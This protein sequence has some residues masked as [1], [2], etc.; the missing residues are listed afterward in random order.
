VKLF[1]KN[2][3]LVSGQD[4]NA[5]LSFVKDGGSVFR[6]C[7]GIGDSSHQIL[8][9]AGFVSLQYHPPSFDSDCDDSYFTFKVTD[10]G[11]E[12]AAKFPDGRTYQEI[13]AEKPTCKGMGRKG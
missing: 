9:D 13:I 11:S 8:V 10:Q 2:G 6:D 4:H 7:A 1:N 12:Y 3:T 5:L